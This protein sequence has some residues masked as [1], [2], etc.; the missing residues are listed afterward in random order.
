[1]SERSGSVV[2]ADADRRARETAAASLRRAG[3]HTI[4][5]E[6]GAEALRAAGDEGVGL[7]VIEVEFPDMS[8]YEVFQKLRH[9]S[10]DGPA[11][12][13][14]SGIRTEPLDR[15]AG[16]LLGADDFIVKPFDPNEL[17]ARVGRFISRRPTPVDANG[18]STAPSLTDREREVLVLLAQGGRQKDIA[19]RLS[20]SPKT[21]G[22]HIQN[23]L[24]K[25]GVHSRA[26]LVARAYMLGLVAQRRRD[27]STANNLDRLRGTT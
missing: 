6:T 16:L 22:T 27:D 8:G 20:I 15:V 23:L 11:I 9:G 2:V 19:H 14:L 26:E 1:V 3:Y 12:F 7:V 24:G 21:V 17:V 10:P 5:V 13:F 4:E 18:G 25:V